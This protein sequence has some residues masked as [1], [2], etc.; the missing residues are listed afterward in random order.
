M[1]IKE[2]P[3]VELHVHLD[4][5][6][7][8]NTAALL[9]SISYNEAKKL[10]VVDDNCKDLNEYLKKFDFPIS[11][12]Q[13]KENLERVS[14]EL[15]NNLREENIIYAEI[16]FAPALHTNLGLSYENIID[17][18][19][20][21]L[22]KVEGLKYNLILCMM[23]HHTL[24]ENKKI[25]DIAKKYLGNG[26]CAIDLAGAEAIY[27]TENFEELFLYAKKLNIPFTIH[28]GEADG[29]DSIKSAI[30]FGT[31]R[32]GHGVRLIEDKEVMNI[33]RDNNIVLEV[34]PT[35]NINTGIF[36]TIE[37]HSVNELIECGI[38]VT[39]NTDNRTVSNTTLTNELEKLVIAFHYDKIDLID[40][41]LNAIDGSFLSGDEKENLKIII[42]NYT[43]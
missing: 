43:N 25:I 20:E 23:R 35:S 4:G 5:S 39:V 37:E 15:G 40:L 41:E 14:Y 17:S 29:I 18:I 21:G 24:S 38:K 42:Q 13:T 9:A 3:K 10:M 30:S 27:P 6:V 12:M 22:S 31:K 33:V 2:F 26:V 34:C 1:N 11:L 8:V 28:A 32:I 19:K 36:N 7:D 16:R